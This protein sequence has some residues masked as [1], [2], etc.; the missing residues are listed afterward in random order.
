MSRSK[1]QPRLPIEVK[2]R[3][4][5]A[6]LAGEVTLAEA[7]R[8]HGGFAVLTG[9]PER[10]YRRRLARLRDG[11]GGGL[12]KGPWPAPKVDA[13]E[14]LAASTPRIGRPGGIARSPR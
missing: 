2:V 14:V 1:G 5:L 12:V 7:A 3:I 8:R 11:V 6:V 13:V 9:I 4:V 10:T